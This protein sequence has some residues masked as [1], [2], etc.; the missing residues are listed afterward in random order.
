[1]PLNTW[2]ARLGTVLPSHISG[3]ESPGWTIGTR[4]AGTVGWDGV[5]ASLHLRVSKLRV[6]RLSRKGRWID[7]DQYSQMVVRFLF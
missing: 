4:H 1:M 7:V 2:A 5:G 3:L 6:V